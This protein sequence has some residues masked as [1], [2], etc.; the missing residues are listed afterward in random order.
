M[1]INKLHWDSK[2]FGF[3]VGRLDIFDYDD[4]A[5]N[6]EPNIY[7]GYKLIYIFDHLCDPFI[8]Q[9]AKLNNIFNNQA[10]IK[11]VDEKAIFKMQ[12]TDIS[13]SA[14]DDIVLFVDNKKDRENVYEL[15][16]LSGNYSRYRI[17][18]NISKNDFERLYKI[19]IDNSISKSIADVLFIYRCNDDIVGFV[20]IGVAG[21][22]GKIGL[23]SVDP[24][25]Q[26]RSIGRKLV[27]CCK[28]Y[29]FDRSMEYLEVQTQYQNKAAVKFY[30]KCGFETDKLIN[31]YHAWT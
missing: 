18:S 3:P 13:F 7:N 25:Y 10:Q 17:D 12:I 28:L 24:N 9:T 2:F 26:G 1:E 27:E 6:F 29:C 14:L 8:A 30:T 15:A 22:T 23:I 20:T 21:N 16:L 5:A 31:I 19:W 11:L 4:L